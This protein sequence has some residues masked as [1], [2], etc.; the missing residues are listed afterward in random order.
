M[1]ERFTEIG[2]STS[3]GQAL[4]A[5]LSNGALVTA[6]LGSLEWSEV[7]PSE[8]GVRAVTAMM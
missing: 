1:V 5:V 6:S 7:L 4:F 3:A 8:A 2:P